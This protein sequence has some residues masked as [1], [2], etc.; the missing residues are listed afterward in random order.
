M[1]ELVETS[2]EKL[3]LLYIWF[4]R[5][6]FA[7]DHFNTPLFRRIL[8]AF[9]GFTPDQYWIY[10]LKHR[11]CSDYL[12]E[13]DWYRS[14][15]INGK[16]ALVLNNKVVCTQLL[17]PYVH[18]PPII[19]MRKNSGYVTDLI[20]NVISSQKLAELIK[21]SGKTVYKPI[22]AGKGKDVKLLEFKDGKLFV[23]GREES[24]E[25]QTEKI[26]TGKDWFL[27][28][29]IEQSDFMNSLFPDS[30]NTIRIITARNPENN[31][32]TV[33][34]AVQRIG[35]KDTV[36]ID[37]ASRGGLVSKID[38]ETGV[39]SEART[40]HSLDVYEQHPDSG[41]QLKGTV[42]PGW[43]EIR[44]KIV[45]LSSNFP[46]LDFIAWDLLQTEEGFCIIEA[47]ASSGVNIVQ[48]WGGQ[49]QAE[50]GNI[51]KKYGIIKH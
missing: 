29:Y 26:I 9:R 15:R 1:K 19:C 37:N 12:S 33:C 40:L 46:Y 25:E 43:K 50:L 17:T 35:R 32:F 47:N 22:S 11:S 28:E 39:M 41:A 4:K 16:E 38:L 34:F 49:R 14:R 20:G 7:T 45:E 51:Y 27:S 30:A 5:I 24:L 48:L 8:L 31:L 36:P 21:E 23:N 18:V 13:F 10:D 42:I 6:L 44:K 2:I 3:K